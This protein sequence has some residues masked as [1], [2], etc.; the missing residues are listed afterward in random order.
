LDLGNLAVNTAFVYVRSRELE[1]MERLIDY[2]KKRDEAVKQPESTSDN[3][4]C[5]EVVKWCEAAREAGLTLPRQPLPSPTCQC[6][7]C[8]E[9]RDAELLRLREENAQLKLAQKK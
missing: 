5:L 4:P 7:P 1:I 2:I 3:K 8:R 6:Q 9:N